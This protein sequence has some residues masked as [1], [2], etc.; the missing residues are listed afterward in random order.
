M[1]DDGE[2]CTLSLSDHNG[3]LPAGADLEA[4]A[5]LRRRSTLL[6]R[7]IELVSL[8]PARPELP[9]R[10]SA[11]VSETGVGDLEV[12]DVPF[13]TPEEGARAARLH[14][15]RLRATATVIHGSTPAPIAAG[16][17]VRAG[18]RE[19]LVVSVRHALGA[20]TG[21]TSAFTAVP[22]EVPFRPERRAATPT[23][24][25]LMGGWLAP[26]EP[27]ADLRRARGDDG[28]YRVR[29]AGGAADRLML[30]AGAGGGAIE[31]ELAEGTQVVWGCLEGDPERPV[32]TAVLPDASSG[33]PPEAGRA[34]LRGPN[35]GSFELGGALAP[36]P[37]VLEGVLGGSRGAAPVPAV[38]HHDSDTEE[39]ATGTY[40]RFSVP[41]DDSS[42]HTYLR[43]G[44]SVATAL[45]GY[46]ESTSDLSLSTSDLAG[47]YDHTDKSRAEYTAGTF[48]QV[49]GGQA[50]VALYG[51]GKTSGDPNYLLRVYDNYATQTINTPAFSYTGGASVNYFGGFQWTNTMGTYVSSVIGGNL[52]LNVG[53]IVNTTVGY[54]FD[55]VHA[56]SYE[57]RKG[58]SL[59]DVSTQDTR[60]SDK[61]QF[62][63]N[64]TSV[65][66]GQLREFAVAGGL[67]AAVTL[68][69][70]LTEVY[71]DSDVIS[72][73]VS[74]GAAAVMIAAIVGLRATSK[75]RE[76]D[77]GDPILSL[78][79]K[80]EIAVLRSDDWLLMMSPDWAVLG[81]NKPYGLPPDGVIKVT[82]LSKDD[83]GTAIV[84][85]EGSKLT[86]QAGKN[87][88]LEDQASLAIVEKALT[89]MADTITIKGTTGD[90]TITI[91]GPVSI[92][93]DVT[94]TG[95]LTVSDAVEFK[96][97]A[98]TT[99]K[100]WSVK[101]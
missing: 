3:G 35:G 83:S 87:A 26:R 33:A 2:R 86:L 20:A 72:G 90:A 11:P 68:G 9:L 97:T 5:G 89:I 99:S 84:I 63:I 39:G 61:I 78:D 31:R 38:A 82:D 7:R 100:S 21:W 91:T 10:A 51:T 62:S 36:A 46:T 43:L 94:I 34:V 4:G 37:G 71:A 88:A 45:E 55:F 77:D 65:K 28:R 57:Y 52:N 81:K 54:Q 79:K 50:R 32:I 16:S 22:A 15:E 101:Q 42:L 92:T 96:S 47:V 29:E 59:A 69:A 23:V 24:A 1:D 30:M 40:M 98:T 53:F 8:D 17:R 19:I 76:L 58:E 48:E 73:S 18:G 70:A 56:D 44:E 85:E 49:A 75:E 12:H 14:A 66:M 25:G 74:G 13:S 93:G 80:N 64:Q 60:A 27:G 67:A 6:P 95:K 41:H